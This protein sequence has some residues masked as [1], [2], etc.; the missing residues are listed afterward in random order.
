MGVSNWTAKFDITCEVDTAH[1]TVQAVF[2]EKTLNDAMI[3]AVVTHIADTYFKNFG[4]QFGFTVETLPLLPKKKEAIQLAQKIALLFPGR[5]E[6]MTTKF[7]KAL[8][9]RRIKKAQ[10]VNGQ[11]R[12]KMD[13]I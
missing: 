6:V 13:I 12:G 11:A 5:L 4:H 3:P 7:D 8:E 1:F 10:V 9:N 2:E